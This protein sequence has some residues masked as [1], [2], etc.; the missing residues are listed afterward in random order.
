[1][2]KSK[3]IG[4][5]ILTCNRQYQYKKLLE[6]IKVN[7]EV[8]YV[9]TVK[10]RDFNYKED[11]PSK[12]CNDNKKFFYKHV[13]EDIG[14]G[15]CK[16]EC[17]KKLL[18]LNCEHIFLIEDDINIKNQDVFK[19]YIDTAE[20]FNIQH[21]NFC[22]AYDS[23]TKKFLTPFLNIVGSDTIKISVFRRLC[24]DFEYFTKEVLQYIGLF[25]EKF[26]VNCLEHAEHTYRIAMSEYTFPF[27]AFADIY[28]SNKYI[29]D[30]GIESSIKH[31][32]K[33]Y[34]NRYFAARN[35][36][37]ETYGKFIN[38]L[39]CPSIDEIKKF[40]IRKCK[41]KSEKDNAKI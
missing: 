35:K 1:M 31:N 25:N 26:Y 11:D 21:L 15:H 27:N 28:E 4:I 14:V 38:V 13:S 8:D 17:L 37:V 5:G 3:N 39:H 41:E 12:I 20:F 18:E 16:N 23:I 9:I 6:E 34:K 36:F 32:E 33:L 22:M 10:N 29:E 7:S 40:V 24:G 2:Y 19:V 30:T